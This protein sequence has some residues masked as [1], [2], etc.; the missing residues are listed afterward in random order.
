M[1]GARGL[2]LG[3]ALGTIITGLRLIFDGRR[4]FR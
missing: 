1:A 3:I 4:Y 2:L